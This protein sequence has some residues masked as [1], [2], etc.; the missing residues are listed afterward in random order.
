MVYFV[1]VVMVVM[2]GMV[3]Y[4]DGFVVVVLLSGVVGDGVEG[5]RFLNRRNFEIFYI[6]GCLVWI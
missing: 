4:F 6:L 5:K 1:F 2:G 3:S